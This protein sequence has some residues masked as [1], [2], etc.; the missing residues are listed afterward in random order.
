MTAIGLQQL[1][2]A[3]ERAFWV[4]MM[5]RQ[6][7]SGLLSSLLLG[8]VRPIAWDS[9]IAPN[10]ESRGARVDNGFGLRAP[11]LIPQLRFSSLAHAGRSRTPMHPLEP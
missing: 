10:G 7:T 6:L 8:L 4:S 11:S 5:P 1:T 2:T 3:V 9:K